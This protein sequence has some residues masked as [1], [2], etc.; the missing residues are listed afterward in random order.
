MSQKFDQ[1]SPEALGL[2]ERL[3]DVVDRF[4]SPEILAK[5]PSTV[6]RARV[7]FVQAFCVT[8]IEGLAAA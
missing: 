4:I 6:T 8:T 3:S 5:G 2:A 1:E 7:L